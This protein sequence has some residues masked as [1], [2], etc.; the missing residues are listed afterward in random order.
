MTDRVH[1]HIKTYIDAA[2]EATT[3]ARG[4]LILM[5]IVAVLVFGAFW[6]SRQDSWINA[7]IRATSAVV[8]FH[9]L[10][11][12]KAKAKE[13]GVIAAIEKE[14]QTDEIRNAREYQRL[15]PYLA[16]DSSARAMLQKLEEIQTQN[17]LYVRL[18][19]FG[20]IIDVNDLGI[21]GGFAFAV[22]LLWFRFA[23][24]H[25]K[26]NLQMT[27][28]EAEKH[29]SRKFCY[30]ALSMHQVLSVPRRL[31]DPTP[32]TNWSYAVKA[33]FFLPLVVYLTLFV[34]D[35]LSFQ[36]GWSVSKANTLVGTIVSGIFLLAVGSLTFFCFTLSAEIDAIW[37]EMAEDIVAMP[38]EHAS[39]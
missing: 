2:T 29:R 26:A 16:D 18:P 33:L 7:R 21:L 14:L 35:C 11:T 19:F 37:R 9:E 22:V 10:N 17:V 38:D 27:F 24:W 31:K 12:A 23:L 36:Y 4:V 28:A 20:L 25:E 6:N 32:V 5:I 39:A 15:R 8:R 34:F 3:R 1:E 30:E 13:A